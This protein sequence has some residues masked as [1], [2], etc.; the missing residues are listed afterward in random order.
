[1]SLEGLRVI[2]LE[3]RRT[4]EI[5][6]LIRK[7]GGEAFVAPSVRERALSEN[8]NA[9]RLLDH[10][11]A[12]RFDLFI[13]TTGVGL[14]FW[15]D[16]IASRFAPERAEQALR[17]VK[18][19]VR[20][21]KPT[22]VLRASGIVPEVSVPEPNTWRE[23]V[24]VL[25]KRPERKLALQE[26]GRPNAEFVAA[27]QALGAE[28]E[29]F[30]L[31]RWELPEDTSPLRAAVHR[32]ATREAD[33]I[34]FT[35]SIQL[36][37]LLQIA[38]EEGLDEPVRSALREHVAIASI[39]PIMSEALAE[40]GLVPDIVPESPKMGPLVYAAAEKGQESLRKKRATIA[41]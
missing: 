9:F 26:Y 2:S 21:P 15:K 12:G 20:G 6:L 28:V 19:L 16:V 31:Y 38:T 14:T 18:L 29:T 34:L 40:N 36:E 30:A 22:A 37:H 41:R 3:S 17:S 24:E 32:L 33:L 8:A 11:E 13:L 5:E 23:I 25:A 27:L 35:S 7:Q 4:V 10:I 39:G 1:M